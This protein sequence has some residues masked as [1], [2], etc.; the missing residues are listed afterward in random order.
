MPQI[1]LSEEKIN[2]IRESIRKY[3]P[4]ARVFIFGSRTDP[5]KKVG[6]IDVLVISDR[7]DSIARRKIRADLIVTLGDRKIDLLV[8]DN[9][10][11]KCL[12]TDGI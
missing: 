2:R 12:Y 10:E 1:R 6:D 4:D 5:S 7:I 8:S 3:D 9:P 11:K